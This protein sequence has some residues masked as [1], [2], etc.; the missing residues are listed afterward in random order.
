M[1]YQSVKCPKG[2]IKATRC[3]SFICHARRFDTLS[4]L[5]TGDPQKASTPTRPQAS[6]GP[7]RARP[8][9][10]TAPASSEYTPFSL[11]E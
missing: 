1:G 6:K 8:Q 3:K 5:L 2:H 10:E 9:R 7:S 4:H 11:E